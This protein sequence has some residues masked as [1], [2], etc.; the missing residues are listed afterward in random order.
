MT[1]DRR[2]HWQQVYQEKSPQE[3]SWYQREPTLSLSLI[4][5]CKLNTSDAIID[6]GGGSSPLSDYLYKLGYCHLSVLDIS[7]NA[8]LSAQQRFPKSRDDIEWIESDIITFQPPHQY[9]LWHDRAVFHFLTEA[10]DRK[11][12][13]DILTRALVPGSYLIIAAFAIGGPEKCSGLN[14]VQYDADKLQNE[15]GDRFILIDEISEHH[16]TPNGDQQAFI[17]FRFQKAIP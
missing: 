14:V 17:Y 11:K 16:S 3:V 1:F 7:E 8:L 6:V 9:N 13:I 15:L 12:Y 10:A 5:Q 2:H 4:D